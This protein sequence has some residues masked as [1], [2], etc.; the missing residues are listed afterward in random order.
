M[1]K[2][3]KVSRLKGCFRV[4]SGSMVVVLRMRMCDKQNCRQ[5]ANHIHAETKDNEKDI[6]KLKKP[7]WSVLTVFI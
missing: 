6:S 3:F 4:S 7:K 1:F 2:S 5:K